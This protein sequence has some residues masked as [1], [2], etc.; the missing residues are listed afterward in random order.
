[1]Q[2]KELGRR[3]FCALIISFASYVFSQLTGCG[4]GGGTTA[5]PSGQ[6][7]F[8]LGI[9][10]TTQTIL[11]SNPNPTALEITQAGAVT[12]TDAR[13]LAQYGQFVKTIGGQTF[14]ATAIGQ[15]WKLYKNGVWVDQSANRLRLT[16][17]DT[18]EWRLES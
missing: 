9:S 11:L 4:G 14:E 3:G 8:T 2:K 6:N 16:S 18:I 7:N 1:M 13:W 15:H 10:G 17:G 5:Q 12:D